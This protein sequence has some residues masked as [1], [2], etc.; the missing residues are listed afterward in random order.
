[1]WNRDALP[2]TD[3]DR[4]TANTAAGTRPQDRPQEERRVVAW[5]GKS[6]I[7]KGDLISSEDMMIDGRVEG[8]IDVRDH[9]LTI[10]PDADIRA[11][12]SARTVNVL[13]SINGTITAKEKVDIRETGSV[14]GDIVSPKISMVDGAVL[15]GKV[16]TGKKPGDQRERPQLT[17]VS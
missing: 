3:R 8:T 14:I 6:V 5:V 16:D 7:F 15:R 13:G 11:D 9:A 4:Q 2:E 1:M 17:A 12:I 10:G